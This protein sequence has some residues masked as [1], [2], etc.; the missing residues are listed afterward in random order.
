MWLACLLVQTLS[1]CHASNVLHIG[2]LF[3]IFNEDGDVDLAQ[4]E[5][6]SV[7]LQAIEEINQN[8]AIL[9][10]HQLQ[11]V[12]GT[13]AS[14]LE[15]A[16]SVRQMR[17]MGSSFVGGVS[18][19]GN[20]IG[21]Y[22]TRLFEEANSMIVNSMTTDTSFG[23]V[24]LYPMKAQTVPITSLQGE[25][26]QDFL[27]RVN[28]TRV[29]VFTT[30]DIN[31]IHF[32]DEF[33][34]G[35]FCKMNI[36]GQFIFPAQTVDFTD[37]FTEAIEMEAR[38]FL[39]AISSPVTARLILEQ[40]YASG[41]FREGTAVVMTEIH[42]LE[43]ALSVLDNELVRTI[44]KGLLT[45]EYFPDYAVHTSSR[46]LQF[47]N[48][49]LNQTSLGNCS[50]EVDSAG[51]KYLHYTTTS[52]KESC[53]SLNFSSYRSGASTLGS[54]AVLSYDAAYT[55]AWGL[56][57]AIDKGLQ[58]TGRNLSQT[59]IDDVEFIGASG[60][61][62]IYEGS[63]DVTN[64]G[65]GNREVGI[66][67]K[68]MNFHY[69]TYLT[70][71]VALLPFLLTSIDVGMY[72]CPPTLFCPS[73]EYVFNEGWQGAYPPYAFA[74][75][76]SIVKIG[77]IF[78]AFI[79]GGSTLDKENAEFLS[80]FLMAV[81]EINNKTDGIHDDLLP[82]TQLKISV[83]NSVSTALTGA[84]GYFDLE[85]SFF[86]SGV[87]GIVNT[88]SSTLVKSINAYAEEDHQFQVIS[89]AQDADLS[90][91]LQYSWKG[92]TIP[93][94]TFIGTVFQN[95]LCSN[96]LE[97]VAILSE[98]TSFGSRA[99]IDLM[100]T[101]ISV[102]SFVALLQLSFPSTTT[103]FTSVLAEVHTSGAQIIVIFASAA[104]TASLLV[105]GRQNGVFHSGM[106]LLTSEWSTLAAEMEMNHNLDKK[107]IASTLRG[108][109]SASF[110]PDYGVKYTATGK[111][112][113]E[114]YL[115]FGASREI[116]ATMNCKQ[117][118]DSGERMVLR[119]T[120]TGKG[121]AELNYTSYISGDVELGAHASLTY[122]ATYALA[123]AIHEVLSN[124]RSLTSVNIRAAMFNSVAF[125][126]VSG[127]IDISEG[128]HVRAGYNQGNRE[129]GVHYRLLNFNEE[130]YHSTTST[131]NNNSTE[132]D[133]FVMI[134]LWSVEG[135]IE[136]CPQDLACRAVVYDSKPFDDP[137]SDNRPAVRVEFNSVTRTF[138][139]LL[140]GVVITV[141]VVFLF[142]T[143]RF[144]DLP[145]VQ[146]SQEPLLYC[147]VLGGLLAGAR[148]INA[149][150]PLSDATCVSG[151]WLG[152][153]SYWFAV[154]AFFLKSWRVNR[155]LAMTSLKRVKI[156]TFQIM[157]YMFLSVAGLVAMLII[158]T[159][160]GDPHYQEVVHV[161]S[162]QETLVPYCSMTHPEVQTVL[163]VIYALLLGT[164][165][166]I[167]WSLREVP[168][169]FSDFHTI[170]SGELSTLFVRFLSSFSLP[171]LS[172]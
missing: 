76:P 25:A 133:G 148:V 77:G 51:N 161:S 43:E 91:G 113:L 67:Y 45:L 162:N 13:G 155:L 101:E 150:V 83:V 115:K 3:S 147:I 9:P 132:S 128:T 86:H 80:V 85:D 69:Q 118:D 74:T 100:N 50:T 82:N 65:R 15:V 92:S 47:Y 87:S 163:Y 140:G 165:L 98:D 106:L 56:H 122:D 2:G 10:N 90:D 60:Q 32:A 37:I 171:F 22:A 1:L 30:D 40:G 129:N 75:A 143:I 166:R 14:S 153:L 112:F 135:G 20:R 160:V 139:Y 57:Y 125:E 124:S 89:M 7:F 134:G 168:K 96:G 29:A 33:S 127:E 110:F 108:V 111:A 73:P 159:V 55:L 141:A 107:A 114:R 26:Y 66:F 151:F 142:L 156:T 117:Y 64:M 137:P 99:A 78:S 104:P 145:E 41:L 71:G 24:D 79:D 130:E 54:Y 11:V 16:L 63:D 44:T 52:G 103:D 172:S 48:S 126:G 121:C 109:V 8:S 38:L 131:A 35:S 116:S 34:E 4:L 170:G 17:N 39:V 157:G 152:N 81:K 146:N 59:I 23:E 167:C 138:F 120:D 27:C 72:P 18:A 21:G 93:L 68:I 169:K 42:G 36:L 88:L 58:L 102:C 49:W 149:G 123:W 158:L 70:T 164:G 5:H 154:M 97:K 144:R 19:L 6:A 12:M 84:T 62:D 61:I 119:N 31:G 53:A 95:F 46:G 28:F 136:K 105:Q 94:D